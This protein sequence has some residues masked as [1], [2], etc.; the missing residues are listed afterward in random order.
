MSNETS[1]SVLRRLHDSRFVT[2]YF[3]GEGIDIGC[4]QDC[5][6]K[7][8][9]LFPLM[10]DVK[11]W[12]ANDGDAQKM[13]GVADN[14]YDFVHSSHCL[15]HLVDPSEGLKNW[16]RILKP[17]GH[18]VVMVPDED[19]Y[20]RGI[21]PSI[22]NSDHKWT[23]TIWKKQSWSSRSINLL[24]LLQTLGDSAEILKVEVLDASYLP[25]AYKQDQ[26]LGIGECAIEF[27]LR[28]K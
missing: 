26:T 22:S 15:E 19:L 16:F 17:G 11:P 12:D 20:E 2:K 5:I 24:Y 14:T 1:K 13:S 10:R 7:Y 27:I 4:G 21:F 25:S 18:M 23:F 3:V 6:G 28:H 8:A 9:E